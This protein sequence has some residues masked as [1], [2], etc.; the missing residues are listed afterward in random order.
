VPR[1][2][3]SIA[4][5]TAIA[6]YTSVSKMSRTSPRLRWCIDSDRA[7]VTFSLQFRG[8]GL[9]ATGIVCILRTMSLPGSTS[10]LEDRV[11]AC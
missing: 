7:H 9:T 6:P 8:G 11:F 2:S 3:G 5:V 10:R 4:W 1:R